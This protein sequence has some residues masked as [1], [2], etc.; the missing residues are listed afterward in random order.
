MF[1]GMESFLKCLTLVVNSS[2]KRAYLLEYDL[3]V[4]WRY[5]VNWL[6]DGDLESCASRSLKKE[7]GLA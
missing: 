7:P 5:S 4:I 6:Q 2:E 3:L 1:L